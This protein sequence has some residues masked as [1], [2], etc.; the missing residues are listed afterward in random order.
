MSLSHVGLSCHPIESNFP[1]ARYHIPVFYFYLTIINC[2]ILSVYLTS[3]LLSLSTSSIRFM[4]A[5]TLLCSLPHPQ[6]LAYFGEPGK[7]FSYECI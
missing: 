7:W 2:C 3:Y 4:K 5:G 1:V 6:G